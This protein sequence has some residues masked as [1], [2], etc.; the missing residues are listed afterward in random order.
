M[1]PKNP[2]T[3]RLFMLGTALIAGPMIDPVKDF[4]LQ[5]VS[6]LPEHYRPLAVSALGLVIAVLRLRTGAPVSFNAPLR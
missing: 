5:V 3:S 1:D 4:V 6:L 2:L